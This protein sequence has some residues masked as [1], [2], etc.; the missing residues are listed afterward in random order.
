MKRLIFILPLLGLLLIGG[1]LAVGL[2]LDPQKLP[3]LLEGKPVP[4]FDL[5]P[6]AG[7]DYVGFS[8]DDLKSEVSMVNVFGSNPK[9]PFQPVTAITVIGPPAAAACARATA[10]A[11]P[12]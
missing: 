12:S 11:R 2:T 1:Y 8:S 6:L 7:R 4:E 5:P 10:T 3:S 9:N